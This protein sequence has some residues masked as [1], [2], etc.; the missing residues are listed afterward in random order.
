MLSVSASLK[1]VTRTK[2]QIKIPDELAV[3]GSYYVYVYF[4]LKR[5]FFILQSVSILLLKPVDRGSFDG[6]HYGD[7]NHVE[8]S[9]KLTVVHQQ[10]NDK[11]KSRI[12]ASNGV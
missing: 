6:S 4:P 11:E 12:Q 7:K 3:R 2:H 1:A 10:M 5:L 8:P 9:L